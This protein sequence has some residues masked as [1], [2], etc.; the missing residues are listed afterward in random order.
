MA[1][2]LNDVRGCTTTASAQT[3]T[4]FK[5]TWPLLWEL[6]REST[7]KL[8]EIV[9]VDLCAPDP[10]SN[11]APTIRPYD[12]HDL[13]PQSPSMTESIVPD[14]L[15][16]R[17][18]TIIM[19]VW[20]FGP[21]IGWTLHAAEISKFTGAMEWALAPSSVIIVEAIEALRMCLQTKANKGQCPDP[22][23]LASIDLGRR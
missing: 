15:L 17:S 1:A 18:S 8:T 11:L 7:L 9:F 10:A 6:A 12:R 21:G 4:N 5:I 23:V 22:I 19:D 3:N 2:T 14:Y 16:Q 20:G 13:S